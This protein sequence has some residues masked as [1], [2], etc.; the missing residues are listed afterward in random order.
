MT[1]EAY[2]K[3]AAGVEEVR[4]QV[5]QQTHCIMCNEPS[6]YALCEPCEALADVRR[7]DREIAKDGKRYRPGADLRK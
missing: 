3:I 6:F 1:K 5:T 7:K 2:D 4:L